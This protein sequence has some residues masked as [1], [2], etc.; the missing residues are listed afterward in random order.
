MTRSTETGRRCSQVNCWSKA[1]FICTYSRVC[2]EKILSV[3]TLY[4]VLDFAKKGTFT[5]YGTP[6]SNVAFRYSTKVQ[7]IWHIVCE[8]ECQLHFRISRRPLASTTVLSMLYYTL[9]SLRTN[10]LA[11]LIMQTIFQAK[12]RIATLYGSFDCWYVMICINCRILFSRSRVHQK[13]L[14]QRIPTF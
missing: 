13:H 5:K 14:H 10:L 1:Q 7:H 11:S 6:T 8:L 9:T 12:I 2:S 3:E 4:I